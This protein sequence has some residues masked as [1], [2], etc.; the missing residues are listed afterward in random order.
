M[1]LKKAKRRIAGLE[2]IAGALDL[3]NGL[4]IE[5]FSKTIEETHQKLAAYNTALS[6]KER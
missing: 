6:T 5:K 1:V 4:T 3:G 2:A